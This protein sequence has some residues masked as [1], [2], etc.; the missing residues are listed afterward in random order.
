MKNLKGIACA[1]IITL[2]GVFGSYAQ[3]GS[4]TVRIKVE[5]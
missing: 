2:F 1:V 4:A 5:V 3:E